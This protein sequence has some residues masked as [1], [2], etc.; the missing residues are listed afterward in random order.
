MTKAPQR[1]PLFFTE[2]MPDSIQSKAF[3][4]VAKLGFDPSQPP[5]I[6][7]PSLPALPLQ[8]LEPDFLAQAFREP[9]HWQVDSLFK[10]SFFPGFLPE[11]PNVRAAVCIAITPSINNPGVLFTRRAI[12]LHNHA[13]QIS[14][15]GGR[16]EHSDVSIAAA[17]MREAQEEVG[18]APEFMHYLG[19]HPV[20]VTTTRFAMCPVIMQ[21]Q[22]GFQLHADP[23][24]VEEIFEVP[25]QILMNPQKHQL[26]QVSANDGSRRVYFAIP[27]GP[28][29]IWGATAVLV[30]NMYHYL[31]AAWRQLAQADFLTQENCVEFLRFNADFSAH[32]R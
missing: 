14:F 26:H 29:F 22:T 1:V 25:L 23:S 11:S 18:I 32:A 31:A 2:S 27:W 7:V 17:A 21:L 28:Y 30:R 24:E 9:V 19:Q 10:N 15:P 12:H 5:L 8:A 20:F 16:I 4:E 3:R 6:P 13:G